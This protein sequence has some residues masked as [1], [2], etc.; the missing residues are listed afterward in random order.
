MSEQE[1]LGSLVSLAECSLSALSSPS[2]FLL[3][4]IVRTTENYY[5]SS[6]PVHQALNSMA[7]LAGGGKACLAC[8]GFDARLAALLDGK[9]DPGKQKSLILCSDGF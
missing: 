4:K 6:W 7:Q 2:F 8:Y 1:W 9:E 3:L 5:R